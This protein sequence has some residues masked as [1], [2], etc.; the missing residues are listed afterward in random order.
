MESNKMSAFQISI[1]ILLSIICFTAIFF[2]LSNSNYERQ[3][4]EI[5]QQNLK[6]Q[7]R[8]ACIKRKTE[9]NDSFTFYC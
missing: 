8:E 5:A 9:N 7:E 2:F 3:Q 4:T 1:I 6:N